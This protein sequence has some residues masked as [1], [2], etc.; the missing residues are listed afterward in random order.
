MLKIC[1]FILLLIFLQAGI[2]VNAQWQAAKRLPAKPTKTLNVD[3]PPSVELRPPI[4]WSM[5]FPDNLHGW[6]ACDDGTL[7]Q[8]SDGGINWRRKTIYPRVNTITPLF[9]DSIG[10]FFTSTQKG[11]IVAH[12][13]KTAV[14]LGTE[15]AG[16]NWKIKF[17]VNFRLAT[18]QNIWFVDE[19]RGWAIGEAEDTNVGGGIIYAT[20]DGGK[21]WSLQYAGD[22]NESFLYDIRFAD[23]WNGWVVGDKAILHTSD[24]GR[25]WHRQNISEDAFFFGIDVLSAD[26]AWVVGSYGVVLHTID[27]GKNWSQSNLPS[28]YEG[29]WLNSVRFVN[30]NRG[31]IVGNDGAIFLTNDGGKT[32]LL[33]SKDKSSYLRGLATTEKYI[34]TFGNDGIILRRSL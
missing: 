16:Q 2:Q 9:I 4:V 26:E 33:E 10:V 23:A 1:P 20:Q 15:N 6:A 18:L 17:R 12:H 14:I 24:G 3:V 21:T 34:F 28:E 27:A 7:L 13:G 22:H 25:T 5:S 30:S 8:T 31:W 11:W 19:K 32:W 29:H